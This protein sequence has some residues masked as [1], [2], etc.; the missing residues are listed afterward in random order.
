L[1]HSFYTSCV[2]FGF[3]AE[4]MRFSKS[5]VATPATPV[6]PKVK[7][8]I[9]NAIYSTMRVENVITLRTCFYGRCA[10]I[11]GNKI[12]YGAAKYLCVLRLT[13]LYVTVLAPRILM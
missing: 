12:W 4:I 5:A 6:S 3:L 11:L 10:Q 8:S 2:L 9:I 13:P 7:T 1:L